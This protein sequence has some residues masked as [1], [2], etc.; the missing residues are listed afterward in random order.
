MKKLLKGFVK[1]LPGIRHLVEQRNQLFFENTYYRQMIDQLTKELTQYTDIQG[2]SDFFA[3]QKPGYENAGYCY[4]CNSIVHF[5]AQGGWWR[6]QYVCL[7]CG[8]IPRERAIMFCIEKH[9]P[10]WRNLIIHESSPIP[11]GATIRLKS[12]CAGYSDSQYFPGIQPGTVHFG[13][14]CENLEELTFEDNSI[15][16]FITQ[17]VMEH[18]FHPDRAFKEIARVLKPG[19]AH[20]FTTPL[21]NKDRSTTFSARLNEDGTIEH[22]VDRPEYHGNPVSLDGSLVTVRWGYDICSYIYNASG[23][24][25]QIDYIDNIN[26]GIRA[27]LIEVILTKNPHVV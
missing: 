20:I 7:N 1:S 11:R 12:E 13:T 25:S 4:A 18:I 24:F 17:D 21:V 9:F 6:D 23:L 10:Q 5:K 15:D 22:L 14:R 8:S 2:T 16:L 3:E 26:L 27:D 19:G